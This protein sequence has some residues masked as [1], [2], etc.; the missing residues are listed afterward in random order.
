V[1]IPSELDGL[2]KRDLIRLILVE[3][4]ENRQ[5]RAEMEKIKSLLNQYDNHNTPSSQKRFKENTRSKEDFDKNCEKRFPG[6]EKGHE[7]VG[8]K[9]PSKPDKVEVHKINKK[10]YV[11]VGKRVK[12]VIDFVDSPIIFTKHIIYRYLSPDGRI[13]EPETNLPRGI[14]GKNLQALVCILKG[15]LGASFESIANVIK[16]LRPDI[17]FSAATAQNITDHMADTVSPLRNAFLYDLRNSFY[18]GCDE[19]GLRHDGVNGY[20]WAACTPKIAIYEAD[21]TRSGK[22]AE[23]ILGKDN[24]ITVVCDGWQAYN[25]YE[26]QR[27]WPHLLNELDEIAEEHE[28]VKIQSDYLHKLYERALEAKTKPPDERLKLV[29]KMNS[30]YELGFL[31]EALSKISYCKKFS[32]TLNNARNDMFTGVIHPEIPLDNNHAERILRKIVIH[33]KLMGCIRN[34]KGQKFIN[35]LMSVMQTWQLQE[36]NIY[37]NLK[38]HAA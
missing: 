7:G 1:R 30:A 5:L 38:L 34:H 17:T 20:I 27:C 21:L 2:S 25:G 23:R 18:C 8:I 10:G 37:Q 26:K 28:D 4:E 3:R 12:P 19:T 32:T 33:R 29:E 11:L 36:K 14:Y 16:A 9:L 35:N 13:V 15:K 24:D 22:V 6:R 31:I